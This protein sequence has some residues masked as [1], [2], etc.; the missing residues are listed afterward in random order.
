MKY[1][2]KIKDGFSGFKYLGSGDLG[3]FTSNQVR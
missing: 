2:G 3:R 1:Q